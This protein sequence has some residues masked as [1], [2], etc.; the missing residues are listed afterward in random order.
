MGYFIIK[1]K[2]H[3]GSNLMK[4][5]LLLTLLSLV[6]LL[7][8]QNFTGDGGK[9]IRLTVLVPDSQGLGKTEDYLPSMI[10]GILVQDIAKFSAISVLDRLNLE[11]V[12]RETESGIYKNDADFMRLGEIT[13]TDYTLTG[14]IS[15]TGSGFALQ[16]QV[17]SNTDGSTRASHSGALTLAELDSFIGIRKAS[18]DLL[19]QLGVTLTSSA[20]NELSGAES[21]SNIHAQ[22]ALAQGITAQRQGTEITA[23]SYFNQAASI[24]PSMIEAVNRSTILSR[25]ISSGN[26]GQDARNAIQWRNDWIKRLTE[27]ENVFNDFFNNN[28]IQYT[29]RYIAGVRKG[30]LDYQRET[31]GIHIGPFNFDTNYSPDVLNQTLRSV[32]DGLRATGKTGEWGL[33][34][35]PFTP[36]S[37]KPIPRGKEVQFKVY[38]QI[39]NS[40]N[41]VLNPGSHF[42]FAGNWE[43]S[44]DLKYRFTTG[45]FNNRINKNIFNNTFGPI[46]VSAHDVTD[47]LTLRIDQ[48]NDTKMANYKN[49]DIIIIENSIPDYEKYIN[50]KYYIGSNTRYNYKN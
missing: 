3:K 2:K 32:Y 1:S 27:T 5:L 36:V 10:Q 14:R 40:K 26:I 21:Q 9:G 45:Q 20:K 7:F 15:K 31:I 28:R 33:T 4:K 50:E 13:N 23:L 16:I 44:S 25:N 38:V 11:K 35:W 49:N 17:V 37:A 34:N 42:E 30:D 22:R 41:K 43:L 6:N 29:I 18:L 12:L 47:I 46:I 48:I 24:N 8:A 19:T 39:V